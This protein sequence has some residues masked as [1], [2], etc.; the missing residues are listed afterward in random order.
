[1]ITLNAMSI[2]VT[3]REMRPVRKTTSATFSYFGVASRLLRMERYDKILLAMNMIIA[4]AV[5]SS[6]REASL[7]LV[8]CI[9]VSTTKQSPSSVEDAVRMWGKLLFPLIG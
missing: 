2:V 8:T 1:M 3:N 5:N 9:D 7:E 6:I 4:P